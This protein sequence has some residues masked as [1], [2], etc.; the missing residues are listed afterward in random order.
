MSLE[1]VLIDCSL[2]SASSI[3]FLIDSG[4]D[5]N[6][7]CGRDWDRI[8]HEFKSGAA[9]FEMVNEISNRIHAYGSEKSLPIERTFRASITVPNSKKPS[10]TATFHVVRKGLRSL[11]GRSTANDL[12][13]LQVGATVDVCDI[14]EDV[15]EF[16]KMPGVLI[17]F[18]VDKSVTPVKNAYFNV[19]AAYR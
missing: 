18:N 11:L 16:P 2:G 6:I 10:T 5:V 7:V 1:D 14:K 15:R 4:A 17:K 19:P 3:R 8:E 12:K 9:N 13:L